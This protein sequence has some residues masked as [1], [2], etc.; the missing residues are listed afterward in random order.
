VYRLPLAG[1]VAVGDA[2]QAS[3]RQAEYDPPLMVL[4]LTI[5]LLAVVALLWILAWQPARGRHIRRLAA[6]LWGTTAFGV[7]HVITEYR[8][9]TR[10]MCWDTPPGLGTSRPP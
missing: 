5:M 3:A 9:M 4:V 8:I 10:F 7:I 2:R 6:V 1:A